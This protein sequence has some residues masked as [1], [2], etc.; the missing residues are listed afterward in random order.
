M[1]ALHSLLLASSSM[2]PSPV[3]SHEKAPWRP[4]G[5]SR[6]KGDT[7]TAVWIGHR[8]PRLAPRSPTL[9]PRTLAAMADTTGKRVE[10]VANSDIGGGVRSGRHAEK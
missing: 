6:A 4:A 9:A 1:P 8:R 5:A 3:C 10:L 7:R 2:A